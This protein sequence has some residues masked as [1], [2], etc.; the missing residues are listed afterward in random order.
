MSQSRVCRPHL[1]E[2]ALVVNFWLHGEI[3]H[4]HSCYYATTIL[5]NRITGSAVGKQNSPAFLPAKRDY[6]TS[7]VCL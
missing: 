1:F 5:I 2:R 3:F 4:K 7:E 6:I